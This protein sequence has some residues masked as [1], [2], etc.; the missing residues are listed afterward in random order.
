MTRHEFMTKAKIERYEWAKK[1][2]GMAVVRFE[3]FA[4][5]RRGT[6]ERKQ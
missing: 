3:R 5:E 2:N 4:R 6:G 1:V